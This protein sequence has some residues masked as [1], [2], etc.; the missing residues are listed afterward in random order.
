MDTIL[1]QPSMGEVLRRQPNPPMQHL[2]P[3]G[4]DEGVQQPPV[5]LAPAT[6][7]F[8]LDSGG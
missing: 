7:Q 3:E 5:C 6:R 1:L 2:H 8:A 4:F